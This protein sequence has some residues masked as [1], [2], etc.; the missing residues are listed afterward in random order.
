MGR[1]PRG[2]LFGDV[3]IE[4]RVEGDILRPRILGIFVQLE[5]LGLDLLPD[6]LLCSVQSAVEVLA[7]ED[8]LAVLLNLVPE[9]PGEAVGPFYATNGTLLIL[10]PTNFHQP[11][12]NP[13]CEGRSEGILPY[14]GLLWVGKNPEIIAS[15]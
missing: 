13:Y 15:C 12:S 9:L 11:I 3:A 2:H 1:C 4:K 6:G 10:V 14:R 7:T 5:E 8:A